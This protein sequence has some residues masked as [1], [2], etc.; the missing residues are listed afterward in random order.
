MIALQNLAVFILICQGIAAIFLLI[1]FVSDKKTFERIEYKVHPVIPGVGKIVQLIRN[2]PI[3]L[4]MGL[5]FLALVFVIFSYVGVILAL[6][7]LVR[8]LIG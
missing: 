5:Y 4:M 8:V 3:N 7:Q 6:V 1:G 2:T